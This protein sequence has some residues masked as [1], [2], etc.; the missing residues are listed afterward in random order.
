MS[1]LPGLQQLYSSYVLTWYR[2]TLVLPGGPHLSL[3]IS[4]P[5]ITL[6]VKAYSIWTIILAVA[7]MNIAPG[8]ILFSTCRWK[9]RFL[10]HNAH[11]NF[12]IFV[13]C[14]E[15][16]AIQQCHISDVVIW[17]NSILQCLSVGIIICLAF[18]LHCPFACRI[19][20]NK[21]LPSKT[22]F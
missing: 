1:Q 7:G 11:P 20:I 15:I 19:I 5:I 8:F 22:M 9:I 12:H 17:I 3:I 14:L 6:E 21:I 4:K 16:H 10:S 13:V 18:S 2:G